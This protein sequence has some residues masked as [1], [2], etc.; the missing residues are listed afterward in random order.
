M[1]ELLAPATCAVAVLLTVPLDGRPVRFGVPLPAAAIARGLRLDGRGVLQWRRLPVAAADELVWIEVAIA[2]PAGTVRLLGGGKGPDDDG[3]GPAFAY[4]RTV[5]ATAATTAVH[6][7]WRWC[8]GTVDTRVRTE[9]RAAVTGAG[10]SADVGQ[11]TTSSSPGLGERAL[12]WSRLPQ[13]PLVAAGLLPPSGGGGEVAR[14]A[15]RRLAATLP[16]LRE[17]PGPD[18]VGDYGRSGGVVTNLEF[19]TVFALLRC[20]VG[21]GEEA[22]LRAAL[23]S[24]RHLVD[25]DLDAR[26]GLPFP[27]G[28]GHRTGAPEPGHAWL[29]GLLW[30]GLVTADDELL[31]AA[32]SI[33]LALALHPSAS[34]ASSERLRDFAWPLAEL[35]A[36]LRWWPDPRCAQSADRCALAIAARWDA[37]QGRFRF[38]EERQP[39][40]SVL[41][42]GWLAGGLLIPALRAH[43]RRRPA[44]DLAASVAAAGSRLV[45]TIGSRGEGVPTHWRIDAAGRPFAVHRATG[46]ASACVVLDALAPREL[47]TVLAR[48]TVRRAVADAPGPDDPDL[49]T[50]FTLVARCDW[51][52]R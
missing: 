17:L 49:P 4:T 22:A 40:G 23:R 38:G 26:T 25:C 18:G 33:G 20:A 48:S 16:L 2:G 14:A 13:A 11:A 6:E 3:A 5:E 32:K 39:D 12:V 46:T 28:P 9:P 47:A 21:L 45:A 51:V 19:D 29:Q 42:R 52:W 27:H 30:L 44:A 36:L 31:A 15:R 7:A 24:A 10:W 43:L 41:E 37:G 50:S 1:V 8:D 35:E 34:A